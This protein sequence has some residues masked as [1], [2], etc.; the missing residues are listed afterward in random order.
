VI[1]DMKSSEKNREGKLG[2]NVRVC[3]VYDFSRD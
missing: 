1:F 2:R 3:N